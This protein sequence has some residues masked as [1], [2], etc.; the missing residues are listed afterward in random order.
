MSDPSLI[1]DQQK[2]VET[3]ADVTKEWSG[4]VYDAQQVQP[5]IAA[6]QAG[7]QAILEAYQ[8]AADY[9]SGQSDPLRATDEY[10]DECGWERGVY[11]QTG[12]S[13]GSMRGRLFN[14]VT[15]SPEQIIAA[16]NAVLAPYTSISCVYFEHLDAKFIKSDFKGIAAVTNTTPA[17]ITTK[18]PLNKTWTNGAQVSISNVGGASVNALWNIT[19][20]MGTLAAL[21]PGQPSVTLSGTPATGAPIEIFITTPGALGVAQFAWTQDSVT[22]FLH[23]VTQASVPLGTTGLTANFSAG[24]YQVGYN[25]AAQV[26][27]FSLNGSVASGVYTGG[28][29]ALLTANTFHW[30]DHMFSPTTT[31]VPN[32]PSRYYGALPHRQP[33]GARLFSSPYG[34]FFWIRAPDIAGVDANVSGLFTWPDATSR[35][36][37]LPSV[38]FFLGGHLALTGTVAVTNGTSPVTLDSAHTIALCDSSTGVC[39]VKM[40]AAPTAGMQVFIKDTGNRATLNPIAV[41]GNGSN[42]VDPVARTSGATATIS[43]NRS[44]VSWKYSGGVWV[45]DGLNASY[46]WS[47]A[48][49]A[50]DIYNSVVGAVESV[51]GQSMRWTLWVDP[52]LTS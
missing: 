20:V 43:K 18:Y 38:G 5:V 34:R 21:G 32:Y 11:R 52:K 47:I 42:V 27:G 31:S 9:A 41:Q 4:D 14:E 23:F 15:V 36:N 30:S 50:S 2:P 16:A 33:G 28:G 22:F 39:T 46:L 44:G 26:T 1:A 6:L 29:S 7:Q 48:A 37:A 12:E 10:Q 13:V 8:D 17:A 51:R 24:S 49:T 35:A 19:L 40:P 3:I 45:L 25:Y